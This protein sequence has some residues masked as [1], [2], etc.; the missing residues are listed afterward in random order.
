MHE[1]KLV[2]MHGRMTYYSFM[3]C[4]SLQ[5]RVRFENANDAFHEGNEVWKLVT[6]A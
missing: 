2:V 6:I 4:R 3:G 5:G 1:K